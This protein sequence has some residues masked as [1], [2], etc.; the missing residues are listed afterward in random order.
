M[1]QQR[2]HLSFLLL[3]SAF[4]F[5]ACAIDQGKSS[6]SV[7][8]QEW[9]KLRG[10][11]VPHDSFPADCT[12]C[13][14]GDNWTTI[15]KD[16]VYDHAKETGY[17]LVGSHEGAECLRCHNDRGPVEL[18][19]VRGCAGCHED[20]HE[21]RMGSEC[22]SCHSQTNWLVKDAITQH[23]RTRFPLVGAHAAA[24]C[25]DVRRKPH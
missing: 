5:L 8:A 15:R 19:S 7:S 13:H 9:D 14:E 2:T 10:P 4:A 20:P 24:A 21:T 18:Y 3:A 6:L 25:F 11:V 12:L 23:A 16:F 22:S 1:S 17:A